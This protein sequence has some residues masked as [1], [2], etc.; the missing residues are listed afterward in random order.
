MVELRIG[1][2]NTGTLIKNV[3]SEAITTLPY[4]VM[5]KVIN[6]I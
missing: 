4:V 1:D 5:M 2:N 3:L 6:N